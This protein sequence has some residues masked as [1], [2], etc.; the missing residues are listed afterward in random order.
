MGSGLDLLGQR[1]DGTTVPVEVSLTYV[2][3]L[4]GGRSI[5]FITDISIRKQLE[6]Q[7]AQL[8][9]E[10]LHSQQLESLGVLAGGIAHDFNNL[11]TGVLAYAELAQA[12]AEPESPT[13]AWLA[14][15]EVASSKA[16]DLSQRMLLYTGKRLFRQTP[17]D[18]ADLV[19]GLLPVIREALPPAV[20]LSIELQPLSVAGDPAQLREAILALVQNASEAMDGGSGQIRV[21]LAAEDLDGAALASALLPQT[22][23]D[24]RYACLDVVDDGC[25]MPENVLRRSVEPF[26][27]T[28]LPGRGLG[29]AVVLGVARA[30]RGTLIARS[31]PGGGSTFRLLI[32]LAP[33]SS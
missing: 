22:P 7:R 31:A 30:H 8:E 32:P 23:A 11:L 26:F 3:T 25:G 13:A 15:I 14:E 20:T 27:S 10:R 29:L 2:P 21:R 4:H 24:G 5:A 18:L 33:A 1:R 9:R 19:T 6:A 12:E 28:K 17:V 16:A